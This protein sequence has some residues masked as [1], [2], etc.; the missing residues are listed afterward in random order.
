MTIDSLQSLNIYASIIGLIYS[1]KGHTTNL[2]VF[3][4]NLST[5][6]FLFRCSIHHSHDPAHC[7]GTFP[8][9]IQGEGRDLTGSPLSIW[10]MYPPPD[11]YPLDT[12]PLG[13]IPL[14][15][16]TPW[17][18]TPRTLTPWDRYPQDRYPLS[19]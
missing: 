4:L 14:G 17:T 13:H 3:R 5:A 12:Y 18:L 10:E 7:M 19:K 16:Y 9:L 15:T 2:K 8:M 1:L 11:T 6:Y